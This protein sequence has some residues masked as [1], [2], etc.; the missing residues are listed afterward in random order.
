MQMTDNAEVFSRAVAGPFSMP[1]S[2]DRKVGEWR[3]ADRRARDAEKALS[4]L[5]FFQGSGPPP[6]DDLVAEA[7]L[8]RKV[9]DEKLKAAIEAM[10]PMKP[11]A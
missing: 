5:P 2:L 8:L 3:S 6:A 4:R 1:E 9:A 11:T 10:K 7:K